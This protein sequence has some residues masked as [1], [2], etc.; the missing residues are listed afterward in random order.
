M[1]IDILSFE[2]LSLVNLYEILALRNAVFIVEQS[3]FY[4]D[5]D[6]ND[7]DAKHVVAYEDNR[8]VAY[9]RILP[10]NEKQ[11]TVSFGRLITIPSFRGK[12]LAK[13]MMESI[14]GYLA[15]HHA[16]LTISIT[17][18]CYLQAFYKHYHFESLGEPFD[19]DGI[20]HIR[21]VKQ[22]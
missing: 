20:P 9:A 16:K 15:H 11:Q 14:L 13:Q 7:Q 22:L 6:F 1:K 21:M 12:G 18:Q 17:A 8:L 2:A 5:I 19:L 4:Q 3:C 10:I